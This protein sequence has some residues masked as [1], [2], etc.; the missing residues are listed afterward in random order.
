MRQY[1]VEEA[2]RE[3][4]R[5]LKRAPKPSWNC[6]FGWAFSG[7]LQLLTCVCACECMCM[8]VYIHVCASVCWGERESSISDSGGLLKLENSRDSEVF[9]EIQI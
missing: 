7:E 9:P 3:C 8:C 1:N 5:I 6:R 4:H 2:S